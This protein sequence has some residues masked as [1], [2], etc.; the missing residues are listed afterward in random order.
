MTILIRGGTVVNADHT[1]RADVLIVGETIAAVGPDLEIPAG[2]KVIDAEGCYVMPGGIDPHTHLDMP[3]MGTF[4]ADDFESGSRAALVGGTTM[5]IDFCIPKPGGSMITA[6][7]EWRKKGAKAISDYGLHLTIT[8]WGQQVHDEMETCVNQ[9]GINSYKHFMAYKGSLMVNDTELYQSFTR[10]KGLGALPMVHAENGE[11]VA[12]LQQSLFDAGFTG[13]EGHPL[14]RPPEVEGEAANRA[15]VIADM[16]GVPLY[17]VHTSCKQALDAVARARAAG[18]RVFC[19]PLI[20][21]LTLDSSVYFDKDWDKAASAVMSPPF[22]PKEHQDA[23]WAALAN[24]TMQ[25]VATD[26]CTFD[27]EKRRRGLGDFRKIPNGTGGLEER[28][29]VLWTKGVNTGRLTME[30]FVGVTS[31]NVARILNCYPKKGRVGV[32][33]DA[34][35][36]IWDPEATKTISVATQQ[37]VIDYNIFEGTELKGLPRTVLS[38]GRIGY[39]KGEVFLKAGDGAYVPRTPF[40]PASVATITF[41]ET[42]SPKPVWRDDVELNH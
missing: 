7:E 16:V 40:P 2:A 38:R 19:E 27:R 11:M 18:Q 9:F 26:H 21:Y 28:M 15:I 17:V 4:S 24:G 30:E 32:G 23:L 25:V 5:L 29:P 14:S 39:D 13:P 1:Q 8:W 10:C 41:K 36:V 20:Q 33:S 3:F 12:E 22:R 34:D 6:Y 31:A 37:S 42:T 35:I